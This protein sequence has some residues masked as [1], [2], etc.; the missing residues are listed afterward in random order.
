[1]QS[2]EGKIAVVTGAGRGIGRAISVELAAHG[3]TVFGV[4][5]SSGSLEET[6]RLIGV[7]GAA[8]FVPLVL[9]ATQE[10]DVQ[11]CFA[12]AEAK[13]PV[14]ILISN[15]G[16][17]APSPLRDL[18]LED[19]EAQMAVNARSMYL[20]AREAARVMVP[21]KRGDIVN[22][23]SL[24]GKRPVAGFA[25]YTASKFAAVGFSEAIARELRKDGIRVLSICPGAV[26]TE[27][28]KRVAPNE[29]PNTISQPQQLASL[30]VFFLTLG[31]GARDL[32]L[33]LF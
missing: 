23:S 19:W 2:L 12:V 1:M 15:V 10:A 21:R 8:R 27:M 17:G 3:A 11:H 24:A 33:D 5:R 25:A 20:F 7:E 29:N 32:S 4:S 18:S 16:G 14:D 13:G 6:R 26:A 9:D 30:I 31:E 22:L 28:R